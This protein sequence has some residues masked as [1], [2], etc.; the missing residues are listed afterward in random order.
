MP[1]RCPEL[2]EVGWQEFICRISG[3]SV[4]ADCT[5][6]SDRGNGQPSCIPLKARAYRRGELALNM[7]APDEREAVRTMAE[8]IAEEQVGPRDLESLS[9]ES[10]EALIARAQERRQFL[11]SSAKR[12]PALQR[13]L[14]LCERRREALEQQMEQLREE[15][16]RARRGLP[17]WEKGTPPGLRARPDP[18]KTS[19]PKPNLSPEQRARK[20]QRMLEISAKRYGWSPQ[21]LAKEKARYA[22]PGA[23]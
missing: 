21:R 7:L 10:L 14:E 13:R 4:A 15:I 23:R 16:E 6:T 8:S 22:M 9:L 20:A 2:R 5:G 17:A 18:G 1:Q 19:H 11:L 3:V 12:V